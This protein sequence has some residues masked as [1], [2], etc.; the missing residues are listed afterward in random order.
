MRSSTKRRHGLTAAPPFSPFPAPPRL[1]TWPQTARQRLPKK[2]P[3]GQDGL[4]VHMAAHIRAH[5]GRQRL[6][7]LLLRRRGDHL[8]V[9]VIMCDTLYTGRAITRAGPR[10]PGRGGHRAR[11][12]QIQALCLDTNTAL[13]VCDWHC[14]YVLRDRGSDLAGERTREHMRAHAR[15]RGHDDT[16]TRGESGWHW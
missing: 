2:P 1:V 7:Q 8:L 11:R 5:V 13:I 3:R 16:R 15:A 10:E 12:T 9:H 6:Q 4:Q 14:H